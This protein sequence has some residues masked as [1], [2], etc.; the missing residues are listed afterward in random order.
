[1]PLTVHV[2]A[3]RGSLGCLDTGSGPLTTLS[4]N[5]GTIFQAYSNTARIDAR[6]NGATWNGSVNQPIRITGGDDLCWTGGLVKG[7]F[8]SATSWDAMHNTGGFQIRLTMPR[9]RIEGLRVHNYGD[10]FQIHDSVVVGGEP[11]DGWSVNGCHFSWMRDD[12]FQNDF[13]H[14]GTIDDCFFNHC[15][16]GYSSRPF[17]ATVPDNSSKVVNITNCL[18]RLTDMPTGFAGPGHGRMW[19]LDNSLQPGWSGTPRDPK[20]RLINN[21]I[22]VT[23]VQ[24]CCGDFYIPPDSRVVESVGNTMVWLTG[25]GFP[26]T[27]STGWTVVTSSQAAWDAR[28]ADWIARH[29]GVD[30]TNYTIP[31]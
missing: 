30:N 21:I 7:T 9:F 26:D 28:A 5:P 12:G 13:G 15:F 3:T 27:V 2:T 6:T 31:A 8:N 19:K 20:F 25:T 22:L 1:V 14:A 29:P 18:W 10:G 11:K 17:D 24:N 23:T 4:S 16:V